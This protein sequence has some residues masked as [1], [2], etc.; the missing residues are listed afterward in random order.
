MGIDAAWRICTVARAP[1]W[2]ARASERRWLASKAMDTASLTVI[3]T[4][5]GWA[6]DGD[7]STPRHITA[8]NARRIMTSQFLS[9]LR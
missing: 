6:P 4:G 7:T 2:R 5:L 8:V 9:A 3:R 1:S